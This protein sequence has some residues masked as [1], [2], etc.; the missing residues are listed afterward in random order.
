MKLFAKVFLAILGCLIFGACAGS[1]QAP[2]VVRHYTLEYPPPAAPLTEPGGCTLRVERFQ[3]A[4]DYA[5]SRIIYREN[6]FERQA[7]TYHR[8]RAS[9]AEMVTFFLARDIRHANFCA[10]VYGYDSRFSASYAVEGSVEEFLEVDAQDR[11]EA[12]LTLSITLVKE[13]EPDVSRRVLFQKTYS[14][15]EFCAEKNP[16]ALSA[17]MSTAMERMS[18]AIS[19]DI[20][21]ALMK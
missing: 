1:R 2:D 20:H 3:A 8:W 11:W 10:A 17:A 13:N 14:Q 5:T 19:S 18:L 15:R 21:N 6:A 12:V 9:P 4:P 7:Y 16:S